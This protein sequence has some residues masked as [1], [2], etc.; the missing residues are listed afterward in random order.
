MCPGAVTRVA[1]ML[2]DPRCKWHNNYIVGML[3]AMVQLDKARFRIKPSC[4][5]QVAAAGVGASC[6]TR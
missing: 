3:S 4:Y 2:L 6:L 5:E 1:G